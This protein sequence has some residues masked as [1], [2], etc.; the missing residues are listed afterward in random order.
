[1][2]IDWETFLGAEG[3]DLQRA[4]DDNVV[5]LDYSW[6]NQLD[7]WNYDDDDRTKDWAYVP[8]EEES[9]LTE[10]ELVW[11][12][13][14]LEMAHGNELPG[15][16]YYYR[17]EYLEEND[18]NLKNNAVVNLVKAH[19][20]IILG[21]GNFAYGTISLF[22]PLTRDEEFHYGMV[23]VKEAYGWQKEYA[24]EIEQKI[25]A[26]IKSTDICEFRELRKV[27]DER[28][29]QEEQIA[30]DDIFEIPLEVLMA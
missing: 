13:L 30:N 6:D 2:G 8:E 16:N 7:S 5:D 21:E 24:K 15:Y 22:D 4:Y 9:N 17:D 14:S 27:L 19:T 26:F 28:E 11:E 3:D 12:F 23:T 18:V 1:M 25:I 20:P 10:E 29:V